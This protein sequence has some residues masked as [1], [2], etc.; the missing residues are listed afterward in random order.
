[1]K[2]ISWNVN[3]IRAILKK[4]FMEFLEQEKPDILCLQETKANDSQV[5]INTGYDIYWN[6]AEK[7]GYSGVA[8]FAKQK[9]KT[10]TKGIGI[11]EHDNEGRV[12]TL[13]FDDFILVN[14][15][16]PNAGRGLDRLGYR[17]EWD[18]EFLKY[19]ETLKKP[20]LAC[21]DFNVAHK[22]IDLARPKDNRKNAG[23]T[24]EE[25]KGFSRIIDAGYKDIWREQHP[26]EVKYSWW[27]YMFNARAKNIGWRIDYFLA[28]GIDVKDSFIMNDVMGSDHCP[29]GI[30]I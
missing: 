9:P 14:A 11:A 13:E 8:V 16:V 7:K 6:S 28:K 22:E 4:N 25:R 21:G 15:Y 5:E 18:K 2:L 19:L 24:D 3:G 20:V 1:M 30:I 29:V 27:S 26:E 10:I 12:L 17:Q 23:F